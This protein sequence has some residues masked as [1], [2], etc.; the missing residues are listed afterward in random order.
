MKK[1]LALLLAAAMCFSLAACGG[2]TVTQDDVDNNSSSSSSSEGNSAGEKVE[3]QVIV[4]DV[5]QMNG[6]F[7]TGWTNVAPNSYIKDL[8]YG[9]STVILTDDGKWQFDPQV[10]TDHQE[11]ENEDGSK[12]YTMTI[13]KDLVYNDGTPI[14]AKD[15]V[16]S[17]LLYSSPEFG[18]LDAD[19]TAGNYYVGFEDFNNGHK[20]NE[21]GLAVDK[22]G[23]VIQG[24]EETTD[25]AGNPT[26][27][28]GEITGEAVPCKTFTGVRLLDDYHFLP[29]PSRR[30]SCRIS[31]S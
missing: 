5:T 27:V 11:T 22:D 12:T 21:E 25:E 16:F 18:E 1:L 15:Y 19:N 17:I 6:D 26:T 8:L 2:T 29:E 30:K 9:Y 28:K 24:W 23:N 20:V 14:T 7:L 13:A 3:N 10:V 4:G 31:M